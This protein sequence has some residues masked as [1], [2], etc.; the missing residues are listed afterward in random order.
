MNAPI[1]I[2]IADDHAL[3]RRGLATL[4]KCQDGFT[5][6]GEATNGREAVDMA[7]ELSPDVIV[8]DLSMPV[9]NGVEATR[10]IHA[11]RPDVRILIL[12][13]FGTSVDIA[14]AMQAGASGAL[15]KDSSDEELIAAVRAVGRGEKAFSPEIKTQ[16][17]KDPTPPELTK[18]QQEVLESI[19]NGLA[20]DAISAKLGI[21]ADA[22]NQHLDAIRKKLGA[23]NRAE[24]VAIALRKHLLKI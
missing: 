1:R 23:A 5:V 18:R 6:V 7:D 9:L 13:T 15:V 24:A 16:L 19:V 17:E 12:T 20:S 8:M 11:R 21:S 3:L 4:L 22:V 14:R 10:K 2:L